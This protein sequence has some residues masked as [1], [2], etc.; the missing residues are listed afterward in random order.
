MIPS[1]NRNEELLDTVMVQYKIIMQGIL[2][3]WLIAISGD[4]KLSNCT[5][6][7]IHTVL[8]NKLTD[9]ILTL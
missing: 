3:D 8:G 1:R 5:V 7:E 2:F 6:Q 4:V 9:N